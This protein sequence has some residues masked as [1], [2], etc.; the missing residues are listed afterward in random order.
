MTGRDTARR[1]RRV[2]QHGQ[3]GRIRTVIHAETTAP[4]IDRK[5]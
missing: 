1:D 5:H 2:V 4:P 3:N